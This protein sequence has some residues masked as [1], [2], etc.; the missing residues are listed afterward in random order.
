MTYE[1]LGIQ[2]RPTDVAG[3]HA[4]LREAIGAEHR[5]V[6]G[7][8]NLNSVFHFHRDPKVREFYTRADWSFVDGM[9]LVL[10]GRLL[11]LPLRREDRMT[12]VDWLRPLLRR[13]AEEGW[14]VFFLGSEPGVAEKAAGIL[15]TECPGLQLEVAHGFFD[16]T[17]GSKGSDAVLSR[18]RDCRPHLL[19]VGMGM[20]R[21]EHWIVDHL[22][23]IEANAILNQGA[24]MDYVAGA[25]PTPPRW[26]GWLGLEWLARLLAEPGRLWR[27][28]LLEPW[29]LL[30]IFLRELLSRRLGAK[31]R[32]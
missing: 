7:H 5:C 19:I 28:Y 13:V 18:I 29:F 16:I 27:R 10:A 12:A 4:A 22:E 9:S 1:M 21:Q 30:P 25:V 6:I 24:F 14:R 23:R 8:H 3:L 11:G 26:M 15:R 2:V 32:R 17:P 31:W 20:P